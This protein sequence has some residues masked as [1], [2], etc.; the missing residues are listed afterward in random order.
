MF[1]N[2]SS[3]NNTYF[4][5]LTKF[6]SSKDTDE[7]G[8]V[9]FPRWLWLLYRDTDLKDWTDL[10]DGDLVLG[11]PFELVI[12]STLDGSI[13]VD[14]LLLLMKLSL[15]VKF[16]LW[17]TPFVLDRTCSECWYECK[18]DN[19]DLKYIEWLEIRKNF[20]YRITRL[21]NNPVWTTRT[22]LFRVLDNIGTLWY[23]NITRPQTTKTGARM[24]DFWNCIEQI[25]FET[26]EINFLFQKIEVRTHISSL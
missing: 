1:I 10:W 9:W 12:M 25:L 5:K 14:A 6:L 7:L 13:D 23:L 19:A 2:F 17:L 20:K 26:D 18:P 22:Y 15:P 8:S 3:S 16:C 11:I 24:W 4:S 21:H